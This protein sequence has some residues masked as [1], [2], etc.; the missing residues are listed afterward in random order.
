LDP[1]PLTHVHRT[2][3]HPRQTI[4]HQFRNVLFEDL[5]TK[6]PASVPHSPIPTLASDPHRTGGPRYLALVRLGKRRQRAAQTGD[7]AV[8][9]RICQSARP[10]RRPVSRGLCRKPNR[11]LIS[12]EVG[13]AHSAAPRRPPASKGNAQPTIINLSSMFSRRRA[14]M[15]ER[16]GSLSEILAD[17]H[18]SPARLSTAPGLP[19]DRGDRGPSVRSFASR[20]ISQPLTRLAAS[21]HFDRPNMLARRRRTWC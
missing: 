8:A 11:C 19:L 9:S 4:G 20:P 16:L 17:A 6:S 3:T 10:Q 2:H 13:R 7:A 12:G 1:Y 21:T 18:S 5:A 14:R 15:I